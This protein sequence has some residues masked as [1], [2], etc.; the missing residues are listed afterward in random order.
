M[1]KSATT[2]P[3]PNERDNRIRAWVVF[4]L[5]MVAVAVCLVWL[6]REL[7]A[8]G[9]RSRHAP[10]AR[11]DHRL[12]R[13]RAREDLPAN[14][15]TMMDRPCPPRPAS[16]FLHRRA[17]CARLKLITHNARAPRLT[18]SCARQTSLGSRRTRYGSNAVTRRN[19]YRNPDQP[20]A[21]WGRTAAPTA[22]A[23]RVCLVT[24][25]EIAGHPANPASATS[26]SKVDTLLGNPVDTIQAGHKVRPPWGRRPSC[27]GARPDR[28]HRDGMHSFAQALEDYSGQRNRG[29]LSPRPVSTALH[30]AN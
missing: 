22:V 19:P 16:G 18:H 1:K 20:P 26:Q 9:R 28:V 25:H 15:R 27:P 6:A 13:L 17:V 21:L 10:G 30:C 3:E 24:A 29:D 11:P 23:V 7:W 12:R 8:G 14:R 5:K 4:A 2:R